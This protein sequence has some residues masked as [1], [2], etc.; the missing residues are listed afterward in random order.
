VR[1]VLEAQRTAFVD[2]PNRGEISNDVCIA[3]G[4]SR[5]LERERLES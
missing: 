3:S 1:E 5:D 2:P 4:V